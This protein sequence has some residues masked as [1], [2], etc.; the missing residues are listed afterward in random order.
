MQDPIATSLRSLIILYIFS[1]FSRTSQLVI[2]TIQ[3]TWFSW[4][5]PDESLSWIFQVFVPLSYWILFPDFP[6]LDS[7]LLC[8]HVGPHCTCTI[9][10]P[11]RLVFTAH[12]FTFQQRN[13][14]LTVLP[15][16]IIPAKG[17]GCPLGR[18]ESQFF[19]PA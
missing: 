7:S 1:W 9:I 14:T 18:F 8:Y 16:P 4:V 11:P 15:S 17:L 6:R 2:Q 10:L 13:F 5:F 19:L 12:S 3:T